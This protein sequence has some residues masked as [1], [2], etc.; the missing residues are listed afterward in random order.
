MK[1][2]GIKRNDVI[3]HLHIDKSTLSLYL[4]GSR[5]MTRMG[6]STFFWYFLNFEVNNEL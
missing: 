2:L 6:K 5:N 1:S 3:S 4:N